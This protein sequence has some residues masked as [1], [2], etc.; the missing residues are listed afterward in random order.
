LK[1]RPAFTKG[2]PTAKKRIELGLKMLINKY[3]KGTGL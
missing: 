3:K 1:L 2:A